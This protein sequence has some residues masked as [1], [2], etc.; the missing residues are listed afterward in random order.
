MFRPI[1]CCSLLLLIF[2]CSA[3]QAQPP[4]RGKD[5]PQVSRGYR[6]AG[7]AAGREPADLPVR[8]RGRRLLW[9][10]RRS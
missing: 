10:I 2:D 6:K 8:P 7:R 9:S 5:D 1:L 4:V 3:A